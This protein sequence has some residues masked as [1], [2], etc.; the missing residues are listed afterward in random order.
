MTASASTVFCVALLLAALAAVQAQKCK[1]TAKDIL[2]PYYQPGAP[3]RN[4]TVCPYSP[5]E[6]MLVLR[7]TVYSASDCTTPLPYTLLDVW[8]ANPKGQYSEGNSKGSDDFTCRSLL[9]TDENGNFLIKTLM[10]GRYDDGGYRPA[11]IH[12]KITLQ[13]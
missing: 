9:E 1:P 3:L 4:N 12:F 7:G 2:G 11:H 13:F 6:D 10:P 5:A 8:Q